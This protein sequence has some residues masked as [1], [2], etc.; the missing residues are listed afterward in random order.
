MKRILLKLK[1]LK[2]N[3][4]KKHIQG[5][6]LD[7]ATVERIAESASKTSFWEQW[8]VRKHDGEYQLAFGHHRRAAAI[9]L[10]GQDREVSCQLEDYTDAQMFVALADENA[11]EGATA[12]EQID[13][14]RFAREYLRKNPTACKYVPSNGRTAHPEK[15]R[16][17][18]SHEHGSVDC[19][20]SF[21]GENNWSRSK[22]ADFLL[23]A[24]NL[25]EVVKQQIAPPTGSRSGPG[26]HGIQPGEIGQQAAVAL[27]SPDIAKE[28]QRAA[29]KVIKHADVAIPV[30]AV[31]DAV[32][33]V[34]K[35]PK[36]EQP[37]AIIEVLEKKV[38]AIK[39]EAAIEKLPEGNQIAFKISTQLYLQPDKEL[40]QE[41]I[42]NR[43]NLRL[44]ILRGLI[45]SL[46]ANADRLNA[47]AVELVRPLP[48]QLKGE[49]K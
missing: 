25:D 44:D 20:L 31:K 30:F 1:D 4:F 33:E 24:S 18:S 10:F 48:K 45:K 37:K 19:V 21:L 27:A 12:A 9:K 47:Y 41:L 28:T 8:V 16:H 5:G 23:M 46:E 40:M 29:A 14:V 22:V 2:S 42:A 17:T 6:R 32:R 39:K 36:K 26:G 49:S 15:A 34:A 11:G 43:A 38:T 3:P 7:P 13:V 35:L